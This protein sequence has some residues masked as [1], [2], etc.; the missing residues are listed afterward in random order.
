MSLGFMNGK[1]IDI[2]MPSPMDKTWSQDDCFTYI[3][4]FIKSR[5]MGLKEERAA[6]LAEA[7]IMKMKYDGLRYEPSLEKEIKGLLG[8]T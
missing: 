1:W 5:K 6:Q 3:S 7:A 2:Q 8:T 4:I